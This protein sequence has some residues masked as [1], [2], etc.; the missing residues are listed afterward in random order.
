MLWTKQ[1][2]SLRTR[3]R[4]NILLVT[5][6]KSTVEA[7][8]PL[9]PSVP[10][11]MEQAIHQPGLHSDLV[12]T[13]PTIFPP[14]SM[15]S[16]TWGLA[17]WLMRLLRGEM[18]CTMHVPSQHWAVVNGTLELPRAFPSDSTTVLLAK[19]FTRSTKLCLNIF[20]EFPSNVFALSLIYNSV[21]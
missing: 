14:G 17:I 6:T 15:F 21:C 18:N 20:P 2:Q 12:P 16:S 13:S 19:L 10:P 11:D 9:P 3:S 7:D 5:I 8:F 4:N 1:D